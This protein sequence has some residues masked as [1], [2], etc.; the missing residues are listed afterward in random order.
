[1]TT[2]SPEGNES[3]FDK[4]IDKKIVGIILAAGES[5]RFNGLKQCANLRG[6]TLLAHVITQALNSNL[7]EI[8]LVLGHEKDKIIDSLG[9]LIK[10]KRIMTIENT[11]YFQGMSTSLKT[12]LQAAHEQSDAVMFIL[13]DQ[14]KVTTELI[15]ELL[16]AYKQ[17][18]G[19]LCAPVIKAQK[20]HKAHE[21]TR[22]GHPVII[23]H[24]LYPELM[25]ITGDIGAR[26]IVRK[27]IEYAI[28]VELEDNSSQFQINTQDDLRKYIQEL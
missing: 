3:K 22:T 23:G 18:N 10:D 7:D 12:G 28:L 1:V 9:D 4:E 14:P 26:E 19:Q 24:K 2:I 17:S 27:N 20:A 11:N 6:K 5:K 15:N 13:G 16:T 25:K 21:E 8:V